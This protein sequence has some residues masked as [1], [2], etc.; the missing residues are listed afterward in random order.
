MFIHFVN[1]FEQVLHLLNV[2][3]QLSR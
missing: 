1:T 2:N 3:L